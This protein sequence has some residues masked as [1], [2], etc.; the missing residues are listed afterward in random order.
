MANSCSTM[1]KIQEKKFDR[2]DFSCEHLL[3]MAN[4]DAGDA[5]FLNDANNIRVDGDD[6]L[7]LT[8]NVLNYYR[9]RYIETK[10]KQ[11]WWQMI[12]LLP[13]S[14]NQTRNVMLNYEVLANIYR[15]RKNH[16][17]DEW[18]E[19]CKWIE[20]LPYS[21]LVTGEVKFPI[22]DGEC[23]KVRER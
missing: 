4:N 11:Y 6:L 20:S 13:S 23:V 8:I 17:L 9:G 15:Q 16:K 2:G 22:I 21:E 12:Q 5:L 19:F 14:Y 1:H 18:R 10:L 7:G 3:N